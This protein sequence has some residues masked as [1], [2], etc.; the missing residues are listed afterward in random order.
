MRALIVLPTYNEAENIPEVL[1]RARAAA[2]DADILV[3]DDSSPDGT[4]GVAEA[5]G[6]EVGGVDVLSRPGKS[7]LG[8]AYREGFDLGRARGYEALMEMDSDLSH[9]P[10]DIPRLLRAL[11][12]GA[13]LV[14]G[15]RYIPGGHI[16][17]WP[18]HRRALSKYGNRYAAAMLKLD[19]HDATSGFRAYRSDVVGR[20]D[21]ASV[22]AD[23]YG[24]QIEMAHRVARAGGRIVEVPIEFVDRVRGTS[25]MS[26]NIVV[27]A[28]ALVTWWG[29]KDRVTRKI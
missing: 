29:V 10:A 13:D 27:E 6:A 25:K 19:V 28:M 24:F 20:I 23:G 5:M 4:A 1:R 9:D 2:P 21:L 7:G 11:D 3:V 12:E 17:H 22:R 15:S 26:T 16:P 14:I 8:S 18:W